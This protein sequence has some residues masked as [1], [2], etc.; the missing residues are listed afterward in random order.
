MKQTPLPPIKKKP[1]NL[2]EFIRLSKR[3]RKILVKE[4]KIENLE[5]KDFLLPDEIGEL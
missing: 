5:S 3:V 4:G 2:K 1:F